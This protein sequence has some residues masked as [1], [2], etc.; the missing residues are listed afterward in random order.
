MSILNKIAFFQNR[1]DEIPNQELAKELA[2]TNN[3]KG[4]LE[5]AENLWSDNQNIQNDCIKVLYEIGYLNP[6]LIAEYMDDFLKLLQNKNNR[7][8]WG[9]MT[10]LST[11]AEINA[12]ELYLHHLAI[13]KA[14]DKGSVITNDNGIKTLALIASAGN[15]YQIEVFPYL[16]NYLATCRSKDVPQYSEKILIAV[17]NNNKKKFIQVLEK[18][19][20]NL[21]S[22]QLARV[23]RVIKEAEAR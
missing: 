23:K 6:K 8:V 12:K 9:G 21:T 11:I 20:S 10:A 7:L 2:K 3:K 5:I 16:L 22:S 18:R 17:N 14:M 1:R 4:V 15:E 19:M 13:R